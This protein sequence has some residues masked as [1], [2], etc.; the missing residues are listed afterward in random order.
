MNKISNLMRTT[1]AATLMVLASGC[2]AVSSKG[3]ETMMVSVKGVNYS[4]D[5][6]V[7]SVDDPA[8][9]KN[10][11]GGDRAGPYTGAGIQCCIKL[12][13]IW[14]PGINLVIDAIIYPVD[15]SD[16]T[17]DLPRYMK[18]FPVEVPQY[19]ADQPT[20]LWVIRTAQGDMNLVASNV[21]PTHEAWPGAVKGWPE[22]SS[23]FKR[24]RWEAKVLETNNGIKRTKEFLMEGM[25]NPMSRKSAWDVRKENHLP[26]IAQFSGPDD[27]AFAEYIMKQRNETLKY[28]EAKLKDLMESKP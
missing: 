20:E 24:H 25:S 12:P 7:F 15:E 27:P 2:A 11:T 18:K 5:V 23:A 14:H 9:P 22:P 19:A 13:K 6:I 28:L 21:D 10:A 26:D 3:N 16:F 8:A 17:R 4:G 1:L